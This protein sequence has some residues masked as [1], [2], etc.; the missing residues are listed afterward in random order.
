MKSVQ[1]VH[2]LAGIC[3]IHILKYALCVYVHFF[4]SVRDPDLIT[5]NCV[6]IRGRGEK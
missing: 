4:L 3:L 5:I 6:A 1:L 2:L